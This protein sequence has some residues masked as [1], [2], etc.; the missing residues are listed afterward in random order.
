MTVA[1]RVRGQMQTELKRLQRELG[2]TFVMVTHDQT[3]VLSIS[4]RIVVM[5]RGRIEQI[6]SPSVLYD[7]PQSRFVA[8]F[9][10]SMNLLPATIPSETTDQLQINASG[11][12][13]RLS[14]P[15]APLPVT[16]RSASGPK[17]F[18]WCNL[19]PSARF[20]HRST[21][22]PSTVPACA[23][24]CGFPVASPCLPTASAAADLRPASAITWR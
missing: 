3:E 14:K 23:C 1:A 16:L 2:T 7:Q 5:N 6:A 11:L 13:L 10:G 4:D 19:E 15:V 21:K 20:R 17:I 22:S 18:S 9:I 8:G 24:T 12:T